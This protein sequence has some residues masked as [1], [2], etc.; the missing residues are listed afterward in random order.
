MQN[1]KSLPSIQ[2]DTRFIEPKM[3]RTNVILK[4]NTLNQSL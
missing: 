3:T 1:A 2:I 4:Y